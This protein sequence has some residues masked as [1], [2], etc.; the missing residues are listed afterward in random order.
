LDWLEIKQGIIRLFIIEGRGMLGRRRDFSK[1][2]IK[3][4]I[5]NFIIFWFNYYLKIIKNDYILT[6]FIIKKMQNIKMDLLGTI[7]S[8]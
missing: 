7:S 4:K 8:L 2:R 6:Y 5:G 3:G 1:E